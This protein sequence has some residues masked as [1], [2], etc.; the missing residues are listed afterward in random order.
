MFVPLRKIDA[1]Q[2]APLD[3]IAT[4]D[5]SF[6]NIHR[7]CRLNLHYPPVNAALAA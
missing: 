5:E 2:V 4:P 7:I 1:A 6:E 3:R